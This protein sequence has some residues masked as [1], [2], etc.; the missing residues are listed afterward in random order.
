MVTASS[1]LTLKLCPEITGLSFT[2]ATLMLTVA[3]FESATP[4]FAL[5]VKLSLP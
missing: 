1:S 2:L 3:V 4:S 5:N